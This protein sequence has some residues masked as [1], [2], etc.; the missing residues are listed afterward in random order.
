M[1]IGFLLA[2]IVSVG[3]TSDTSK[4]TCAVPFV[5][6]IMSPELVTLPKIIYIGNNSLTI[7]K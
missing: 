5:L 6:S 4:H 3:I 1:S 2:D 7:T